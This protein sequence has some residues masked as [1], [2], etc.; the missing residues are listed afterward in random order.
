MTAKFNLQLT[1]AE[2]DRLA[3]HVSMKDIFAERKRKQAR[4][5]KRAASGLI[6]IKS[7]RTQ[8]R[9]NANRMEKVA[10]AEKERMERLRAKD[11]EDEIA[12]QRVCAEQKEQQAEAAKK[13]L[14][15]LSETSPT[16]PIHRARRSQPPASATGLSPPEFVRAPTYDDVCTP[17]Y[18]SSRPNMAKIMSFV[19]EQRETS[20]LCA[21]NDGAGVRTWDSLRAPAPA[22]EHYESWVSW[23]DP[24]KWIDMVKQRV[25][26]NTGML[27][28]VAMYGNYNWVLEPTEAT[29]VNDPTR[30]PPQLQR[31]GVDLEGAALTEVLPDAPYVVRMTRSDAFER[32]APNSKLMYRSMKLEALVTEMALTLHAASAGIG[33]P[34]YAA[35]SWRFVP[36]PGETAQRYGLLMLIARAEG[37]MIEYMHNLDRLYPL[38]SRLAPPPVG[39]RQCAESAALWLAGLCAHIAW[40]GYI[41]YDM[42]PGNLLTQHNN[43]FFMSDFD[44]TYYCSMADDVA[45]LKARTFV[46]ILLLCVHVRAYGNG[47]FAPS[48][49]GVLAPITLNLYREA[50]LFP[51]KFGV[52]ADWIVSTP[53]RPTYELGSFSYR[54]LSRISDEGQ[55]AG[56]QLGMMIFEYLFDVSSGKRPPRRATEWPDWNKA[57]ERFFGAKHPP[58]VP[59]LLRFVF[60]YTGTVAEAY[61]DILS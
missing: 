56:A 16:N 6:A 1:A 28:E 46:N 19:R 43:T 24:E 7:P 4:A 26:N 8:Q 47:T 50:V 23:L 27:R 38:E 37:D 10:R 36:Q 51:E 58:L 11:A 17:F 48:F 42:K 57:T 29:P 21:L 41:N 20:V 12:H 54:E 59:Q 22:Y 60:F 33:P 49:L 44:S 53:I 15:A 9:E 30:W 39:V 61:K 3:E 45:G 32:E 40:S 34:V 13:Q 31:L 25:P 52:G 18:D 14:N 2:I 5:K 55:R 35:V